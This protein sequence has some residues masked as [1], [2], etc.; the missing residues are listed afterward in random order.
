MP[1]TSKNP[2]NSYPGKYE[3]FFQKYIFLVTFLWAIKVFKSFKVDFEVKKIEK[4]VNVHIQKPL[5]LTEFHFN[6]LENAP[7]NKYHFK[8]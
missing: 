3:T 8:I 2:K 5:L 4:I 1:T 7:Q 6:W